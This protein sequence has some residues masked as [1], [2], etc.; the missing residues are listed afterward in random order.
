[1]GDYVRREQYFFGFFLAA[2]ELRRECT[3]ITSCMDKGDPIANCGM[4]EPD[5][6]CE[7]CKL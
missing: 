1:M 7:D 3:G 5:I 6:F 2:E 4:Q